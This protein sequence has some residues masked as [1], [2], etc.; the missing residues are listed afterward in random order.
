MTTTSYGSEGVAYPRWEVRA[1]CKLGID[2]RFDGPVCGALRTEREARGR[3]DL[4]I[5]V[6]KAQ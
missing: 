4:S 3:K 2:R 6:Q 5:L 1:M